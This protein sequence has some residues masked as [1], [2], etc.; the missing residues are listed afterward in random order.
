MR[1]DFQEYCSTYLP[2]SGPSG[3]LEYLIDAL[4]QD[5]PESMA[6]L[7]FP[8]ERRRFDISNLIKARDCRETLEERTHRLHNM[9][10]L[11][12]KSI[13]DTLN[14]RRPRFDVIVSPGDSPIN[15]L[16]SGAGYPSAAMP[17]GYLSAD[18]RTEIRGRPVGLIAIASYGEDAK[19]MEFMAGWERMWQRK[20]PAFG[21]D[22][23]IKTKKQARINFGIYKT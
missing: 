22:P 23:S 2:D 15:L 6:L 4:E 9:R 1:D 21:Y 12:R 13:D 19:L 16:V 10:K 20:P 11:C 3:T 14:L 7:K 5:A 17:I 18:H 8:E